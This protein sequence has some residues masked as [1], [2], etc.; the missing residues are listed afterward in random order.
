MTNEGDAKLLDEMRKD[1]ILAAS[2][3]VE[4]VNNFVTSII[5]EL[6]AEAIAET[7]ENKRENILAT[8]PPSVQQIK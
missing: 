5:P 3:I 4:G 8:T 6:K 1:S 7:N 2:Q